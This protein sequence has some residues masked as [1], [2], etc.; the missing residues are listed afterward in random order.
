MYREN[1]RSGEELHIV[2]EEQRPRLTADEINKRN[3][4]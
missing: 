2:S 3:N 1:Y 4:P